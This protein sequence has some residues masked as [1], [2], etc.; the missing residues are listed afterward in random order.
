MA[1]PKSEKSPA[2]VPGDAESPPQNESDPTAKEAIRHID[3]TEPTQ[4]GS[5]NSH[6]KAD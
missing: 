2:Q 6:G 1:T 4:G 3:K 5:A